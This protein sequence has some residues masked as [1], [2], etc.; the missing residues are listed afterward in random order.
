MEDI[1]ERVVNPD[2]GKTDETTNTGNPD[3]VF[4]GKD[5]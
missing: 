5:Y 2:F 1:K 3:I 4:D